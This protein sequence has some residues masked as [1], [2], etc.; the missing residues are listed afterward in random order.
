MQ[1]SN[2]FGAEEMAMLLSLF[3]QSSGEYL[4]QFRE[5]L[6]KVAAGADDES[7]RE[8]L[9]RSVHS[10][11]GAALQLGIVHIGHLAQ[12]IEGVAKSLR[13][14]PQRLESGESEL[15]SLSADRLEA[16]IA[17]LPEGGDSAEPPADLI[18]RLEAVSDMLTAEGGPEAAAQS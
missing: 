13:D 3:A 6:E 5:A 4:A 12:A 11:K 15:L 10:L 17:D 8:I 14:A 9:Q 2:G 18:H 7:T 1:D 16:Y